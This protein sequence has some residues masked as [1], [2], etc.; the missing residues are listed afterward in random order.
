LMIIF[1]KGYSHVLNIIKTDTKCRIPQFASEH[2]TSIIQRLTYHS[3][4]LVI[5]SLL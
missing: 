5:N 3:I 4:D 1:Y 2:N